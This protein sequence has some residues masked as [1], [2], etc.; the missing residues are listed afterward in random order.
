MSRWDLVGGSAELSIHTIDEGWAAQVNA[1]LDLENIVRQL[2]ERNG[3]VLMLRA[4]GYEW[5]EIAQLLG[6]SVAAVRNSFWRELARIRWG[7]GSP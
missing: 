4:A 2:T 3:N 6:T 7:S 1:R 5:K